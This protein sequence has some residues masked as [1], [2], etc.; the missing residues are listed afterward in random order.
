MTTNYRSEDLQPVTD[1]ADLVAAVEQVCRTWSPTFAQ[2]VDILHAAGRRAMPSQVLG[3]LDALQARGILVQ[4]TEASAHPE[5]LYPEP[6][7][8]PWW[9]HRRQG[10]VATAV[11]AQILAAAGV[12]P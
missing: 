10:R 4:R 3:V 8:T 2:C 12:S 9:Q 5:R 6:D 1:A 11:R 7:T